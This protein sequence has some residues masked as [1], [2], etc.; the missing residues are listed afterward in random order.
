MAVWTYS[1]NVYNS[2]PAG[3]TAF[4]LVS[5]A[6][7]NIEYLQ[8]SHIH[9][10]TSEDEG[11]S[12]VEL[13]ST[14][15]FTLNTAGTEVVLTTG[16]TAGQWVRVQR[17]TP[18]STEYVNFQ[19]S[20]QLTAGQLNIAE[21]FSIYVDQEI[22]DRLAT[23]ENLA[24]KYFGFIDVT[25]D[26]APANPANGTFFINSSGAGDVRN[27]WTGIVG[28]PVVGAE[29]IVYDYWLKEWEIL[30]TPT[31]QIGV[32]SIAGDA[33]ITVDGSTASVPIIGI[34]V[35]TTSS[36]GA[37][38][39]ADKTK[40]NSISPGATVNNIVGAG[41]ITVDGSTPSAPIIGILSATTTAKGAL[42]AAD[43]TKL[44]SINAGAGV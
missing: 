33:P 36:K 9:A 21:E 6:G 25:V 34:D 29:Q 30:R 38:S 40:L 31:S 22:T 12:W 24:F 23:V 19:P 7:Y 26:K 37:L 10:Y 35:A 17:E 3:T 15:D 1:G 28:E 16:I 27:S 41:A 14:S 5:G 20:S 43:K 42:S 4:P 44:N 18:Y 32:N 11:V 2:S 13:S 8:R 39:A